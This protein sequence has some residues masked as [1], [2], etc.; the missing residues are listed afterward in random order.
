MTDN[1]WEGF[2]PA[3][4]MYI[5][6]Q[7][8][9]NRM[10]VKSMIEDLGGDGKHYINNMDAPSD[11]EQLTEVAGRMCY[12]SFEV[13]MNE[14]VTRV[15]EGNH[16]YLEN[17]LRSGHGSVLEHAS[18]TVAFIGVSRVFTHEMVRHRAGTA[19]SQESLRFVRLSQDIP[20]WIPG[21][22]DSLEVH[23]EGGKQ[24]GRNYSKGEI[25]RREVRDGLNAMSALYRRIGDILGV[26]SPGAS[27]ARKKK[28]TS[29]MRRVAPIGLATNLIMT[30]NHRAWRHIIESRTSAHAEEELRLV[31]LQLARMLKE[32]YP[33]MY[34][35][36]RETHVEGVGPAMLFGNRKV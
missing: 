36:M 11:G 4:R 6:G 19:F 26:D 33:N 1:S 5:L 16:T 23:I 21:A 27:F 25:V 20:F 3:P 22:F 30:A 13:G 10:A 31:I 18:V 7:T 14:N 29:A 28:L 17:I 9:L 34:G 8:A 2:S 24:A 32:Q 12:K 15:R 35:D